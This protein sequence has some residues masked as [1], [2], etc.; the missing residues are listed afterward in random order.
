MSLPVP[1]SDEISAFFWEGSLAEKLLIQ[2]CTG[3]G[4]WVYPPAPACPYCCR[5][6]EIR[7]VSGGGIVYS[8]AS[9]GRAL[10]PEFGDSVPYVVALVELDGAPGARM[11][12]NLVDT[13]LADV[14]V[15]L[16]V[17]VTFQERGEMRLPQFR[18]KL[19]D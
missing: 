5:S 8:F 1:Q 7:Q 14:R 18:Q 15:G 4:R 13:N 16:P 2:H 19:E 6:L 3:C 11:F 17:V 12:C 9:V 10:A